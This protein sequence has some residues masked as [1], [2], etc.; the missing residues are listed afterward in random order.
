MAKRKPNPDEL[1]NDPSLRWSP[2][3]KWELVWSDAHNDQLR[4]VGYEEG[5]VRLATVNGIANLPGLVSPLSI[6][7]ADYQ[8][9]S[10]LNEGEKGFLVNQKKLSVLLR[11]G[12]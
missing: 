4:F 6:R 9:R 7:R 3:S 12:R 1:A 5:G 10:P 2:Y 8:A 11:K